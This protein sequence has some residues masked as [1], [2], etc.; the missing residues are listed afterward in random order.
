MARRNPDLSVKC[1]CSS[2]R[3]PEWEPESGH[4]QRFGDKLNTDT[5]H[6]L[7]QSFVTDI[8]P[9]TKISPACW[10]PIRVPMENCRDFKSKLRFPSPQQPRAELSPVPEMRTATFILPVWM[11][12]WMWLCTHR[13]LFAC[14]A[15]WRLRTL[16]LSEPEEKPKAKQSV[17]KGRNREKRKAP[18]EEM[19]ELNCQFNTPT[20]NS[21]R[22]Q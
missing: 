10:K 7:Q 21:G 22:C 17:S 6:S 1:C 16:T 18:V 4:V 19:N 11:L 9:S 5:I 15:R 14:R 12:P 13:D 8:N 2:Y 20:K 3:A